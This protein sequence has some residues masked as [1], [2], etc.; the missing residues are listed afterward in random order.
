MLEESAIAR[1]ELPRPDITIA[2]AEAIFQDHYGIQGE[3]VELGSQQ[4]RNFRIDTGAKRYVAEDLPR[5]L[6]DDRTRGAKCGAHPSRRDHRRAARA[7]ARAGEIRRRDP[8]ARYPRPVL[9]GA[10]SRLLDGEPLTRRKFLPEATFA[11]FGDVCGRISRALRTSIIRDLTGR[12][13][14]PPQVVPIASALLS[15]VRDEVMVARITAAMEEADR[16]VQPL[17]EDLRIQPIHQ[18]IT[19]DNVVSQPDAHGNPIPTGVIDF[20]DSCAAGSWPTLWSAVR[21]CC[22]IP[23]AMPLPSCRPS[24][25]FHATRPLNQAEARALWPLTVQRA[26]GCGRLGGIS[27]GARAGQ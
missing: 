7:D 6:P 13:S 26:G 1:A 20:G 4:D 18:D 16:L 15:A 5:R 10:A 3:I 21:R 24:K 25:A 22:I 14:G 12:F 8:D 2:D 27:T 19:D 11:A 23:P 9:P 17:R